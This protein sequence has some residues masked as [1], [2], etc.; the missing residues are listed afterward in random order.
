M[1]SIP[2]LSA[3]LQGS[4][5]AG[6]AIGGAIGGG[7]GGLFAGGYGLGVAGA[8]VGA[9]GGAA[10]GYGVSQAGLVPEG[11]SVDLAFSAQN[12]NMM[13]GSVLPGLGPLAAVPASWLLSKTSSQADPIKD[14]FL[15]F[16]EQSV[17]S[18]GDFIDS[19]AP[20]YMKKFI[21]AAGGPMDPDMSRIRANTTM[22]V[23]GMMVRRGEGSFSTTED[24]KKTIDAASRKSGWLYAIRGLA[25]FAGP[26]SPTFAYDT[27]DKNGAWFYTNTMVN[28]WRKTLDNHGGEEVSAFEE[29]AGLYGLN[30]QTF[31]TGKTKSITPA[32]L[33]EDAYNWKRENED[34]YKEFP[35]SAYLLNDTPVLED[36]FSYD[37]YRQSLRDGS[38]VP[39]TPE[40][41]ANKSNQLAANVIMERFRQAGEAFMAGSNN[42]TEDHR[43]VN[44]QLY[45]LQ[46]ALMREYPGYMIQ[47]AGTTTPMEKEEK[48]AEIERWTP[49]MKKSEVG[50]AV[51]DYMAA[52]D[53]AAAIGRHMGKTDDWWMTS[54]D[55]EAQEI[56]KQLNDIGIMILNKVPAFGTAWHTLFAVE[57]RESP[58]RI[59]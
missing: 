39:Y 9:I 32:P 26:T 33:T 17:S 18:V 4:G 54:S 16:G 30:P 50:Q 34:M 40:Q 42:R 19:V 3:M 38:R 31:M 53:N 37:A 35:G 55:I 49:E 28:E 36:E 6:A 56:R 7:L 41:W 47:I 29:F 11:E 52:R 14:L 22:E 5:G 57:L 51:S 24:I 58:E 12:V 15:P 8:A 2:Y 25:A 10:A 13:S 59:G 27:Q 43:R 23:A 20:S 48:L 21:Q 45:N 44:E 46:D 1:F